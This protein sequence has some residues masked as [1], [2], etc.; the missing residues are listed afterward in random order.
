MP[1]EETL[2]TQTE[3]TTEQSTTQQ[4]AQEESSATTETEGVSLLNEGD[5]PEPK[6]EIKPA[7]A[8]EK[9]EAFKAPE[10]WEEKGLELNQETI[11]KAIPLFKELG[12]SQEQAQKLID[13]YTGESE[14]SSDRAL[15]SVMDMRKGWRDAVS[16]DKNLGHRLPEVKT[17]FSKMLGALG[18]ANLASAFKEAMDLTGAGDHPAFIRAVDLWSQRFTE[19]THVSGNGPSTEGQR[20]PGSRP[21]SAAR[22]LYPNNP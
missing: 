9:Y 7:G 6:A 16:A 11:D 14:A 10:G 17:N 15:Q 2:T 3:T 8:P 1:P 4:T 18:D 19:G 21:E 12:L 5:K 13:F 20:A 22:A